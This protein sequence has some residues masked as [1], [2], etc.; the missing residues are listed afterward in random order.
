M[1]GQ[2]AVK[3][4]GFPNSFEDFKENP[5]AANGCINSWLFF[6]KKENILPGFFEIFHND[7]GKFGGIFRPGSGAYYA[8]VDAYGSFD[9]CLEAITSEAA[10][11]LQKTE[12]AQKDYKVLTAICEAYG[13]PS[14]IE[15][16]QKKPNVLEWEFEMDLGKIKI[17]CCSSDTQYYGSVFLE[18]YGFFGSENDNDCGSFDKCLKKILRKFVLFIGEKVTD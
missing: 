6:P 16:F 12:L 14:R 5:D 13:L 2:L 11:K 15:D 18:E 1:Q 3:N 7:N 8:L 9:E 4:Y 17:G 10:K